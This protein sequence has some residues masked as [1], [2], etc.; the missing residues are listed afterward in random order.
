LGIVRSINI[1]VLNAFQR[2]RQASSVPPSFAR[3]KQV[4][5]LA[6]TERFIFAIRGSKSGSSVCDYEVFRRG[7]GPV[8]ILKLLSGT[9]L[10]VS[11]GSSPICSSPRNP[12][13]HARV[14]KG[15]LLRRSLM[16]FRYSLAFVPNP[17]PQ[18]EAA[19]RLLARD[20]TRPQ[21]SLPRI[22]PDGLRRSRQRTIEGLPRQSPPACP[23]RVATTSINGRIPGQCPATIVSSSRACSSGEE[24]GHSAARKC[25]S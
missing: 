2:K 12:K 8:H 9:R 4:N 21:T 16:P 6:R 19:F 23:A 24:S 18:L 3:S 25:A 7:T 22:P 10:R 15:C 13:L 20:R 11:C 17:Q 14:E 5:G 1:N